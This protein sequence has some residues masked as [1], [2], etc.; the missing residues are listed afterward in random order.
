MCRWAQI[1]ED[2]QAQLQKERQA[3]QEAEIKLTSVAAGNSSTIPSV[4][5]PAARPATMSPP[6]EAAPLWSMLPLKFD[7]R[8]KVKE[9][10][11]E[12]EY[13]IKIIQE[14]EHTARWTGLND[15]LGKWQDLDEEANVTWEELRVSRQKG[16]F[17]FI[18]DVCELEGDLVD[19]WLKGKV[20]QRGEETSTFSLKAQL[21]HVKMQ[22]GAVDPYLWE[23]QHSKIVAKL[24]DHVTP[25]GQ[26]WA[27]WVAGG[28]GSGKGYAL[29]WLFKKA[30]VPHNVYAHLDVDAHRF[31]LGAWIE[32]N[33]EPKLMTTAAR[34]Q[35][36]AGYINDTAMAACA[37]QRKNFVV[38]GT[39]RDQQYALEQMDRMKQL[40]ASWKDTGAKD[41][42]APPGPENSHLFCRHA[43]RNRTAPGQGTCGENWSTSA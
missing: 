42:A 30:G 28:A 5:S 38:D 12:V 15:K 33:A 9:G 13:S 24:A 6:T 29:D 34:T 23:A 26:P 20:V 7:G 3:R 1:E 10:D 18:S 36:E 43:A 40:S 27:L 31:S 4:Q 25:N 37:R 8:V 16:R 41:T 39:M 2:L 22:A 11:D 35:A 19:E 14:T 21:M 32:D 17:S